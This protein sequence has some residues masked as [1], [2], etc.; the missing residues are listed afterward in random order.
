M[1]FPWCIVLGDVYGVEQDGA[2]QKVP[3]NLPKLKKWSKEYGETGRLEVTHSYEWEFVA[4]RLPG[5]FS[6]ASCMFCKVLII[7]CMWQNHWAQ[8]RKSLKGLKVKVCGTHT[9]LRK[10]V[11]AHLEDWKPT[12]IMGMRETV[13]VSVMGNN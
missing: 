1:W 2:D 4:Q 12:Y 5:I 7:V 6:E 8:W 3:N 13:L 11:C 10:N 9:E